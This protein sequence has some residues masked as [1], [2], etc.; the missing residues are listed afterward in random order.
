M[1]FRRDR[2]GAFGGEYTGDLL[3]LSRD[4]LGLTILVATKASTA[5]ADVNADG[6]N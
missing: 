2:S 5:A 4:V 1:C 6:I 3:D